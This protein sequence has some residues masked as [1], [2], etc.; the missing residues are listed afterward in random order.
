[1]RNLKNPIL[2]IS[3]NPCGDLYK[4][5]EFLGDE[6]RLLICKDI[7]LQW[8]QNPCKDFLLAAGLEMNL[9]T[10]VLWQDGS[11]KQIPGRIWGINLWAENNIITSSI[12]N[13]EPS[14]FLLRDP[15]ECRNTFHVK[16]N[17]SWQM[18]ADLLFTEMS[19]LRCPAEL[20]V[21]LGLNVVPKLCFSCQPRVSN[22]MFQTQQGS[23]SAPT[24]HEVD[25]TTLNAHRYPLLHRWCDFKGTL[26]SGSF[27]FWGHLSFDVSSFGS[28][29]VES[30]ESNTL[31]AST[32]RH[33]TTGA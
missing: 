26:N 30:A 12:W 23:F 33:R 29:C 18:T 9:L 1:M 15:A 32:P 16:Y 24:T 28:V 11:P 22:V 21:C 31:Q 17:L 10:S 20:P 4:Q 14:L 6:Y 27:T 13:L 8:C 19:L 5:Y 3:Q 25:L 2:Q 7:H